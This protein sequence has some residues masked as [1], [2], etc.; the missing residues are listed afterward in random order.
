MSIIKS[1]QWMCLNFVGIKTM[2]SD[3]ATTEVAIEMFVGGVVVDPNTQ[4]PI[5]ILK[6]EQGKINLPIWIGVQEAT[7]ILSALKQLNLPRPQTH[8]F[9]YEVMGALGASV[10]RIT[11]TEVRDTTYIAELVCSKGDRTFMF[12][13]RPSDAINIALRAS[14]PIFVSA[15]VLEVAQVVVQQAGED[16]TEGSGLENSDEV[17]F[18][19]IEKDKWNDILDGL[20]PGDFKYRA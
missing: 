18:K 3:E 12:D 8:D 15:S 2:S 17:D 19:T 16:L 20:D 1:M 11:I 9:M 7:G 4:T 13:C 10:Q 5:V 14:A 6:D